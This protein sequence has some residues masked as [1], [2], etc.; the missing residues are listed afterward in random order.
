MSA[1]L[2]LGK[3]QT[4][5]ADVECDTLIVDAPYSERT[6]AGHDDGCALTDPTLRNPDRVDRKRGQRKRLAYSGWSESDVVEF[7]SA[8]SARVRGWMVSITDHV[9]APTWTDAM[10]SAGRYVFAPV[11]WVSLNSRVRLVGDGPSCWSCY[12]IVGRPKTREMQRWGTL[13]G[14][15]VDRFEHAH[16]TRESQIKGC[17]PLWLMRSL[18][19][20]YSRPGD[21]VCDPCAG[22]C[23]TLLAALMEG[24][25][26]VGAEML[27]EHYDIGKRRLEKGFTQPLFVER[28]GVVEQTKLGLGDGE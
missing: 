7:V 23:T 5:L 17:K 18:V 26:A 8:W 3:W 24:R 11:P 9:L 25:R 12:V 4:V 2:R 1:D 19:R 22:G 13:P 10:E 15:Y 16:E 14:A 21:L 27:K 28:A 20:D 6:H